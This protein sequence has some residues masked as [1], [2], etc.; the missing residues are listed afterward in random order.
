MKQPILILAA[1]GFGFGLAYGLTSHRGESPAVAQWL[2]QTESEMQPVEAAS[3]RAHR[4][5]AKN[6]FYSARATHDSLNP[7]LALNESSFSDLETEGASGLAEAQPKK[8][9]SAEGAQSEIK[10]T[11]QAQ[12]GSPSDSENEDDKESEDAENE[13]PTPAH[14]WN[15]NPNAHEDELVEAEAPHSGTQGGAYWIGGYADPSQAE[16]LGNPADLSNRNLDQWLDLLLAQPNFTR[17]T[18]FT[19]LYLSKAIDDATFY[20]VIKAMLND[21]RFEMKKYAII[22]LANVPS[23]ESYL[24]MV[25]VHQN[26]KTSAELAELVHDKLESVYAF[27]SKNFRI[28]AQAIRAS[29]SGQEVSEEA[30]RI[31]IDLV[32]RALERAVMQMNSDNPEALSAMARGDWQLLFDALYEVKDQISGI[33]RLLQD[34]EHLLA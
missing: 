7:D 1:I 6:R 21:H 9:A 15:S 16:N 27:Q 20:G 13:R 2:Q 24:E 26:S 8:G 23:L 3:R 30:Q 32:D 34:I 22:A 11:G 18:Q 29:A 5:D 4:L 10:A 12:A 28:L 31:T 14:N 33:D 25:R 19:E 17:V